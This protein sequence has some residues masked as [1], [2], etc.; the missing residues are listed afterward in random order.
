MRASRLSFVLCVCLSVSGCQKR[1]TVQPRTGLLEQAEI[2][3]R[4][5]HYVEAAR[6]F[7]AFLRSGLLQERRDRILFQLGLAHLLPNSP[8]YD[9][10]IGCDL[11]AQV[12]REVPE[13]PLKPSAKIILASQSE[14]QDLRKQI[15]EI[16]REVDGWRT[17]AEKL[18][19]ELQEFT[20]QLQTLEKKSE[21]LHSHLTV[22]Q[23]RIAGLL[24]DL[25]KEKV[26]KSQLQV[27]L[28]KLQEEMEG[29]KQIDLRGKR[30]ER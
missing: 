22:R 29:L 12:V 14:L 18:Q 6:L 24:H 2:H 4:S 19:E 27:R 25:R 7:E 20:I 1:I 11:L 26:Q 30:L 16:E 3:L 5:G 15:Q 28:K 23:T 13:S 8:I 21:L 17:H 10:Q 9:P